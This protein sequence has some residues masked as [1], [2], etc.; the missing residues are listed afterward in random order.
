MKTCTKS[1]VVLELIFIALLQVLEAQEVKVWPAV[2]GYLEHDVTLP[3]EFIQGPQRADITQV[4]WELK[5]P[6]DVQILIVSNVQFGVSVHNTSLK[7]R[8]E[9]EKQSL[10]IKNVEMTDAG[11]YTCSIATFPSGAFEGTTNLVVKQHM[12]LSSGEVSAIVIAVLL[13]LAI[14]TAIVYLRFIRRR[15]PTVRHRVYID[16]GGPVMDVA[17]PSFIVRDEDVVYTDVKLKPSRDANSP[18][19]DKHTVDDVTYSEVIVL[20]QQPK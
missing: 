3:C 10:I 6:E 16:A 1:P 14:V 13:L 17:R 15:D 11:S 7:G 18:S 19:N 9:L 4:Q 12:P 5:S 20:R 2:T 8:V